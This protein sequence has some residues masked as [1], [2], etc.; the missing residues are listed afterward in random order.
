MLA[1]KKTY[2]QTHEVFPRHY[3]REIFGALQD[4][5]AHSVFHILASFDNLDPFPSSRD[6]LEKERKKKVLLLFV[7]PAGLLSF[8]CFVFRQN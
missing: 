6:S 4:V 5:A 8:C 7:L 1:K 3:S 2:K